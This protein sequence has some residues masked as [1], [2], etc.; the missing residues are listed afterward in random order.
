MTQVAK[1]VAANAAQE[2]NNQPAVELA[3]PAK[4]VMAVLTE[5]EKPE[6]KSGRGS[7]AKG[8]KF[9]TDEIKELAEILEV[10]QGFVIPLLPE[11]K[12]SRMVTGTR[13]KFNEHF[14][15]PK[16]EGNKQF[17]FRLTK[18]DDL[19]VSRVK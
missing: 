11:T 12:P 14:G 13:W 15:D 1:K 5:E 2:V 18:E 3:I 6:L 8:S 7:G 16:V 17:S 9:F 19:F 4:K 10:G